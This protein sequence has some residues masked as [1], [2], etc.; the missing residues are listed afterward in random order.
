LRYA[1]DDVRYLPALRAEMGKRLAANG[2]EAWAREEFESLCE[3]TQY[4]FDPQTSYMKVRNFDIAGR[5]KA[6]RSCAS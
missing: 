6:S 1:A 2:H 3:P 5:R 4:Q